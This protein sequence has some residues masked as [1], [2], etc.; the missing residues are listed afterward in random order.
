MGNLH[1]V[2]RAF[3]ECGADVL[4]SDDPASIKTA[5]HI[6]LPGVG[7]FCNAMHNIHDAGWYKAIR[8]EVID[9]HIPIMGICLGMQLLAETGEEGGQCQGLNLIPGRITRLV[10]DT[11]QTRIPHV[12][13]NEVHTQNP[14]PLLDGIEDGTDFY[15]VHSFHFQPDDPAH[16]VGVTPYCDQFVSVVAKGH[17]TGVQFHPEKSL[18]S[19]FAV[20]RNFLNC[21]WKD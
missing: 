9:M 13:W 2:R 7:A 6:V 19:G 16:A 4:V 11:P 8:H 14:C 1:S 5:T 10:A 3:E 12:G 21:N 17:I 15:F 20:I 18:K